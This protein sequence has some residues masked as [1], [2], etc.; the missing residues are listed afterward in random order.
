[1][2]IAQ[3]VC[4]GLPLPLKSAR[5]MPLSEGAR[6]G[7][8]EIL[9]ALG[10][11]GMGEVYRAR[12]TRL[13]RQVAIKIL[14]KAFLAD[15]ERVARFQREAKVLASLNHPHIA[16]IYGLDEAD[17]VNALVMELVE[18][19][20]L[21]QR[22]TREPIPLDE[23]LPIAKQI[24]EALEA[25]HEQGIIHRD[26]KPANI[27]VRLDGT[28]KV[29]DFG[30]AKAVVRGADS[31][32]LLDSPTIT[33][34]AT[35][36]GIVLGTAPY[37]S[38]EQAKGRPVD[39]RTDLWA[40]GAVLY[41]LL[42]GRRAFPGESVTETLSHVLTLT[43]D[44]T[45]LPRETP[46]AIRLLLRHCLEKDPR[47]RLD[48][49]VAAR[50]EI[51][52]A[53]ASPAGEMMTAGLQVRRRMG[54]QAITAVIAAA[55]VTGL[56]TWSVMRT[57]APAPLVPTRFAIA[58][59]PAATK[60]LA[61][62]GNDVTLSPD[63]RNLVYQ[64]RGRLM[65]RALD[66]LDAVP[67]GGITSARAP[68]F[69]PDGRW[70]GFFAGGDLKKVSITGE[71][72]ITLAREL[73]SPEAG[74]W[75]DDGTIVVSSADGNIGLRR[76]P[77]DGGHPTTL[78]TP[79]A[80]QNP[81]WAPSMLPHGRGVLFTIWGNT[82]EDRQLAVIDFKTG[83]QKMLLPGAVGAE[84]LETGHLVYA[85]V[86]LRS[87]AAAGTLWAVAFDLDR[88]ATV[89]EPV[90]ISETLEVDMFV[91]YAVS[92]T[93]AL[94]Y[95]PARPLLRTFV[96]VDRTGRETAIAGLPARPYTTLALSPD[97]TRVA[98]ASDDQDVDIWT[99]DFARETL[100]RLSFEAG[101][102]ALPRWTPDGRR[103]VF[104][105]DRDGALN[106]YSLPA[107]GS[108]PVERLFPSKSDQWP[109][110]ITPD[111]TALL[112]CEL[113]PKSGFDMFRL[114]MTASRP[115][116]RATVSA[117]RAVE[118]TTL[119]ASPAAEYAAN[120]SPDGR[121]FAYQSTESGGRFG[122]YVRPYPDAN[123][124]RWQISTE[125]GAAPV[126]ARSGAELFYLDETNTLMSVPVRASG[127]QLSFGKPEKVLDTR[128]SGNFYSYD[129]TPDGRRFLMMKE[130]PAGGP[131]RAGN[132]VVVLNWFEEWKGRVPKR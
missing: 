70:I 67:L 105:S 66:Q 26:L 92:R 43:P 61:F 84:Y 96:W 64:S 118:A 95:V 6:L 10:A 20:D 116:S 62:Q 39:R 38:P 88:L 119:V 78:T 106:T 81:H 107:D 22:L 41:E 82:R 51:D 30:L 45:R 58:F 109:N 89:G 127:V 68:F 128:Y 73:G 48:S 57:A 1:M 33:S 117:E 79:A 54:W 60:E 24:A 5:A 69:S 114:P 11:G 44:W 76:V 55:L 86:D 113:R 17:G 108:G 72:V 93:G 124:G 100:T 36:G 94:V 23:A 7:S 32:D 13:D 52:E 42:S 34:P 101:I 37:M 85:T 126:W 125:G 123:L 47:K 132:M 83:Q 9:S 63:G 121:Y 65:L 115:A 49:A 28:V 31:P 111:G 19:E 59:P 97:G 90:R 8:Y 120:I 29:L 112:L 2:Q 16:A 21:A 103:I 74:T 46:A 56:V 71:P 104:Q 18:G 80:T 122:V 3:P 131:E 99:W 102:D 98:F 27:R 91:D 77:A 53:L 50:I 14:P 12:D 110:S 130:S 87:N 75:G 40:F 15:A 25:A 35:R 129:V 4:L